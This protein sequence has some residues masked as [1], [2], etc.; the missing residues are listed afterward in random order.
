MLGTMQLNL[1]PQTDDLDSKIEFDDF[2]NI[3]ANR[4]ANG[5][6]LVFQRE[7]LR[8]AGLS[9]QEW[10]VLLNLRRVGDCHLRKLTRLARVDVGH[11]SRAIKSLEAKDLI[12][13]YDD[14][15][16]SRCK[17]LSVTEKGKKVV[18]EIW[19]RALDLN[20]RIESHVGKIRFR[21]FKLV[22]NEIHEYTDQVL[23]G[24]GE[25]TSLE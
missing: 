9:I 4:V 16:D 1:T 21:N 23:Y 6:S 24:K 5:L 10:R 18:A 19:P 7:T 8:P 12:A 2:L 15:K 17:L 3:R 22:L 13:A 20:S 25:L 11:T 14:S